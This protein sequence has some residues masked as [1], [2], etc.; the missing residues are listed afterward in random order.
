MCFLSFPCLIFTSLY[1][2]RNLTYNSI[3][4]DLKYL[5]EIDIFL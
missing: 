4:Y 3:F 1:A 5:Y 2:D